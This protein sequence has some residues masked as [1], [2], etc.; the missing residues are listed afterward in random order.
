MKGVSNWTN[1]DKCRDFATT[2]EHDD[3]LIEQINKRVKSTDTLWHL[4]DFGFGFNL[5]DRFVDLR[6]RIKCEDIRILIGNHD[7]LID[8]S[9]KDTELSHIRNCFKW[10]GRLHYGKVGG[11]S[12]VFCHYAMRTWPWQHHMSIMCYAHSHGN[13]P[14][15]NNSLSMDVGVDTCLFGHEKYTPYNINEVFYIMDTMKGPLVF[16]DHHR[17]QEGIE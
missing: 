14:D 9:L 16:Q 13:L 11:R 1:K 17:P 12:C 6:N 4:G 7:H 2:D 8:K 3:Y 10:I 5:K 15:D